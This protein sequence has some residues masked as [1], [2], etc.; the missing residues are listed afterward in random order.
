MR[1]I[2]NHFKIS[3]IVAVVLL[4]AIIVFAS[5]QLQGKNN[6]IGNV[7]S[8][9]VSAI[10]KPF[11]SGTKFL[12]GKVGGLLTDDDLEAENERLREEVSNLETELIKH[13]LD[14]TELTELK[15]LQESLGTDALRGSYSLV[16][17]NVLAYEGSDAFQFFTIDIGTDEGVKRDSIVVN[18]DGLI[19][20]VIEVNK[21][22]AKVVSIVDETN[23]V[24]FQLYRDLQF[25]GV[26]E[27]DGKGKLSGYFL[28]QDAK[29]RKG[30]KLITSG[31]G[32]VYPAGLVVGKVSKVD[33]ADKD[34]LLTVK[35]EPEVYFKGIKKVAVLV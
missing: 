9:V 22:S 19:G 29:V 20:R 25:I 28:D 16:A 34:G 23:K 5:Y 24:G 7:A 21:V 35:I 30:D 18:G 14:E 27:G 11:S 2:Q 1:W 6:P 33:R 17:A 15:Q 26:C 31:I 32:G 8:M 12:S 4:L 10:E 13:R 3:I